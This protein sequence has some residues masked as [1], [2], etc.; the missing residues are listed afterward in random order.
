MFKKNIKSTEISEIIQKKIFEK[1]DEKIAKIEKEKE[2]IIKEKQEII[3]KLQQELANERAKTNQLKILQKE[4]D[5][6]DAK[7]ENDSDHKSDSEFTKLHFAA[8][9]NSKE[10]GEV[11]ISKGADMNAIDIIYLNIRILLLINI[12]QNK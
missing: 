1:Y 11:L 12:I 7:Y 6:F 9:N 8:K 3:T 4:I 5:D 2:Q 10:I